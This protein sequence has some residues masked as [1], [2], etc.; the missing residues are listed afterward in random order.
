MPGR[1][2]WV[3][4]K[5]LAPDR[6]VL[7]YRSTGRAASV[8]IVGSYRYLDTF[9][10]FHAITECACRLDHLACLVQHPDPGHSHPAKLYRVAADLRKQLCLTRAAH[11]GLVALA[12]GGVE[13][14]RPL[15]AVASSPELRSA[16]P[17]KIAQNKAQ[18][19]KQQ[20]DEHCN[21]QG[22]GQCAAQCIGQALAHP[23]IP[24]HRQFIR[25]DGREALLQQ[26]QRPGI[27]FMHGAV[28]R[29]GVKR[30]CLVKVPLDAVTVKQIV[31]GGFIHAEHPDLTCNCSLN[32]SLI[33]IVWLQCSDAGSVEFIG[34]C[35]ACLNANQKTMQRLEI[36]NAAD[37][38]MS[39]D[40]RRDL[41]VGRG[42]IQ[43]TF[44]FRSAEHGVDYIG[45][46]VG[47]EL[48]R[49]FPVG[50]NQIDMHTGLAFPQFPNIHQITVEC[51]VR[52]AEYIRR[53]IVVHH[54]FQRG[55]C[56]FSIDA[57]CS[58]GKRRYHSKQQEQAACIKYPAPAHGRKHRMNMER[59]RETS[60]CGLVRHRR[61][62]GMIE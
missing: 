51:T 29:S 13:P 59:G 22:I 30:E 4:L 54:D 45:L 9:Q 44:A 1:G 41:R 2:D 46:P 12:Q 36:G 60:K 24:Q 50:G 23:F 39:V 7:A 34:T 19:A 26:R 10:I 55:V 32:Q 48:L 62:H 28:Q 35:I 3:M 15:K 14:C 40:R 42:E 27:A 52:I 43:M 37:A 8:R 18:Y 20:D 47:H 31:G 33:V 58:G 25:C 16:L 38:G 49:I 21:P 17:D 53:I 57:L 6:P 5:I 61:R 11:D 56:I